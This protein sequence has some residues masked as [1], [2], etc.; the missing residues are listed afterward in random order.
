VELDLIGDQEL[1]RD[2]AAKF[3]SASCPLDIVRQLGATDTGLPAN[4]MHDAAELGWFSLLVPAEDGGGSVSG[5]GL[6]DAAILAEERGRLLQPGPFVP[7]NVVASAL[8]ARGS[9]NQKAKVLPA[10][11]N[12][13]ALATWAAADATGA[14]PP[15][16]G[17]SASSAGGRF[18]LSG[19]AGLVQDAALADWFLVAARSPTGQ[20]QFLVASSAAGISLSPRRTHD[21]TQRFAV[22]DFEGVELDADA[23]VGDPAGTA[24][25]L[26]R[27]LQ[28]ALVLSVAETVGAIEALFDM[29]R[30]Y[31]IDRIAFGRP[32]GSFQAVK[33]QLADMSL[34]VEAGA[35]ISAAATRAVQ[36]G[37][38]DAGE[39]AS[40]AKAW[41][42]DTGIDIAQGCFQVFGGI[43]YTWEHDLHLFLRRIT[44]NSLLYGQPDW[45][46]ERICEI[47]G[48]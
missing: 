13:E 9:A 38:D 41:V 33:H 48:L 16:S 46:R 23:V 30:R 1:L 36:A 29:T 18:V 6:R 17:L 7:M 40:M 19:C 28:L 44:M 21:I 20:Q 22:V 12:G 39:I 26:E 43:G 4:Y 42:G 24:D 8:A 31:A 25:D 11:V 27:Q 34:S 10:I 14:F 5:D 37:Q 2:T 3:M 45:H 32:I 35:S 47:H 15:G